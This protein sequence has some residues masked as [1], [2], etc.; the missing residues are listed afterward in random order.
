VI[1][2]TKPQW[3]KSTT[4]K[5]KETMTTVLLNVWE[6]VYLF[7]VASMCISSFDKMQRLKKHSS[8]DRSEL[9]MV[10]GFFWGSF[11][12]TATYLI[13]QIG[14]MTNQDW[15]DRIM[16]CPISFLIISLF[17]NAADYVGFNV[18]RTIK[19]LFDDAKIH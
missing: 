11:L 16:R 6:G 1:D 3:N 9:L 2:K 18:T 4:R 8:C 7:S 19:H 12:A 13:A 5:K 14:M 15:A 17:Y 10:K